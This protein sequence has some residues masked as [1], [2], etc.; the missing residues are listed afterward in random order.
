MST[1]NARDLDALVRRAASDTDFRTRLVNDP[2]GTIQAEGYEVS[3]DTLDK[4]G[5]IDAAAAEAAL[6]ALGTDSADRKAAG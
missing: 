2:I 5:N 1:S 4:M 6:A 3:Q